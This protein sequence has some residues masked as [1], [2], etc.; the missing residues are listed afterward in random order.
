MNFRQSLVLTFAL[1]GL[2]ATS[3]CG[4]SSK[5]ATV[6]A[7]GKVT[8]K[9]T[10]PAAGAMVVFHPVSPDMEKLIGGKPTARKVNDDGTFTLTTYEDGDG[11]PEGEY[12]V[13]IQWE[14]KAREGKLSLGGE[15]A[16]AGR[17]MINEAK[18]GNP[19]KPFTKVTVKKGEKNDF[20]FDVE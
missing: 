10:K 13:T 8:F 7:T 9:K 6:P 2:I 19:Q 14:A 3:G 18:Y 20:E 1:C 11:A 17:S 15:G 12:G 4:G 16:P 5:P